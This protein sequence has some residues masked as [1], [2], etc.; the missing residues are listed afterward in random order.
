ML[1]WGLARV[2]RCLKGKLFS[3]QSSL[4][5][6][7]NCEQRDENKNTMTDQGNYWVATTTLPKR[8]SIQKQIYF[9]GHWYSMQH[10]FTVWD[11]TLL[12]GEV[13]ASKK[14]PCLNYIICWQQLQQNWSRSCSICNTQRKLEMHLN[15]KLLLHQRSQHLLLM[16]G[17]INVQ[18]CLS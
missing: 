15:S 4:T 7:K 1:V 6:P 12:Y 9:K 16:W 11:P 2:A 17:A 13:S 8:T 5:H 14:A 3:C 10:S 18:T